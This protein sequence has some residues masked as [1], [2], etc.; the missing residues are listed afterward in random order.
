MTDVHINYKDRELSELKREILRYQ[1]IMDVLQIPVK[2]RLN[3][4]AND[5]AAY[6]YRA[7]RC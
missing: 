4:S 5:M 7:N 6:H 3:L 2:S 1:Q